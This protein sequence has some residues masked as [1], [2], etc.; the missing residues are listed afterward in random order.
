LT[1]L[2]ATSAFNLENS[3]LFLLFYC[4]YQLKCICSYTKRFL[5]YLYC[6]DC[7]LLRIVLKNSQIKFYFLICLFI[8]IVEITKIGEKEY[9]N[10]VIGMQLNGEYVAAYMG[11]QLQ[12]HSVF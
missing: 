8:L 4:A 10:S 2:N 1:F 9:L 5:I 3:L 7:I 6:F 12:L 11:S